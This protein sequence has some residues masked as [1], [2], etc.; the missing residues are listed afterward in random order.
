MHTKNLIVGMIAV[1]LIL[2]SIVMISMPSQTIFKYQ[3]YQRK[4]YKPTSLMILFTRTWILQ[5]FS[6]S[7]HNQ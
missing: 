6:R 7:I 1:L 2:N 4:E 3:K 5:I